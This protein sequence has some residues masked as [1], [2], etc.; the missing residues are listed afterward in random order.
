MGLFNK[1]TVLTKLFSND[2]LIEK[3]GIVTIVKS[4]EELDSNNIFCK[5]FDKLMAKKLK[6]NYEYYTHYRDD[7]ISVIYLLF[8]K[9]G[10]F[11]YADLFCSE[12]TNQI[13]GLVHDK[14]IKTLS[15]VGTIDFYDDNDTLIKYTDYI[16]YDDFTCKI[17]SAFRFITN[18]RIKLKKSD[19]V[20]YKLVIKDVSKVNF[21]VVHS[22]DD[23]MYSRIGIRSPYGASLNKSILLSLISNSYNMK[24][25]RKVSFKFM[26]VYDDCIAFDVKNNHYSFDSIL[27]LY[28]NELYGDLAAVYI[29]KTG[30]T[31]TI[32][33]LY[34]TLGGGT[35]ETW[36]GAT[37][38]DDA[39]K[40]YNY[41]LNSDLSIGKKITIE[42]IGDK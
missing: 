7:I 38:C 20:K 16:Y 12:I 8:S 30:S 24:T 1:E 19:F 33:S 17:S 13:T 6:L 18:L 42:E 37:L 27:D 21:K 15:G 9:S 36:D 35:W 26:L 39:D 22:F 34:G 10:S 14:E 4:E 28:T 2:Y 32:K 25:G 29:I 40:F 3:N 11:V 5:D 23:N 41:E 31:M